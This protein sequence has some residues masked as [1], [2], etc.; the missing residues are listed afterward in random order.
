MYN[1]KVLI[2]SLK[3]LG[4]AKAPTQ[5]KDMIIDPMGQWAHPGENTRIPS[6]NITMDNVPYPVYADPNVGPSRMMY[7]EQEYNFPGA[8]YVDEYPQMKSGGNKLNHVVVKQ[9]KIPGANKGLFSNQSFRKGQLIGLAHSNG[10]PVGKIGNMHNHSDQPNMYS[11]KH[12]NERYVYA[13]RDIQPGEE[14]TTNYRLQPEL[15]QPEDFMRKGGSTS[16]LPNKKNSRAYSR[17]LDATNRLFAE[18]PWFKKTKSRKNKIY[19]PNAKYYQ[20][21]GDLPQ[22]VGIT[23]LSEDDRSHY[24]PLDDTIYLNPNASDSELNHELVH[25][26]QNRTGRL[27]SNPNLPQQRPPIVASDEQAASYYTRKGDDV[28]YYLNNLSTLYPN[29]TDGN[30]WTEDINRFIPEQI[31]YDKVI[32]PLMYL[33]PNTMEGEAEMFSQVYGPPPGISFR[34]KGGALPK[35]QKGLSHTQLMQ[36]YDDSLALYNSYNQFMNVLK[37][38]QYKLPSTAISRYQGRNQ[39]FGP[40]ALPG[41]LYQNISP[42]KVFTYYQGNQPW[43]VFKYKK[44]VKPKSTVNPNQANNFI[45]KSKPCVPKTTVIN[46]VPEKAPF[47]K[48]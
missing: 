21:G 17:S 40:W 32:D 48:N 37:N 16:K 36:A 19:D 38:P 3:K 9:S 1:K 10:Q 11:V 35:A 42:V 44:P 31:K 23:Y 13:K 18:H 26:W 2:D 6:N 41:N 28:D 47:G 43:R 46:N 4:S 33:D 20:D 39:G 29:L 25:A 15:E 5:K 24:N 14:L 34:K 8:D 22:N 45:T 30:I 27:R 12:G 7:P